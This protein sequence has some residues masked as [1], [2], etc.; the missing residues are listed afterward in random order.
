MA[1]KDNYDAVVIG[2]GM[3][4]MTC[5]ALLAK[6]KKSVLV[7][8]QGSKPGGCC[9]STTYEGFTYCNGPVTL[10][11]AP[12]IWKTLEEMGLRDELKFIRQDP[13][14]RV[15]GP[16]Y[17]VKISSPQS[18]E[19][20]LSELFPMKAADIRKFMA[21][22]K[23]SAANLETISQ[24]VSF[25][26][27]TI[28]QKIF[29]VSTFLLK[30][31]HMAKYMN[32]TER[33]MVSS[34]LK[35]PKVEGPMSIQKLHTF[36]MSA[37]PFFGPDS[38]ALVISQYLGTKEGTYL[39]EGGQQSLAN[40]FAKGIQK[41][42]GE[43]ALN[44]M[45][46]KILI[47]GNR[48]VG[49]RLSDGR[50][51]K[52]RHV[53]SNADI[54][55]TF[56]KLVGNEH[57][58]PKFIKKLDKPLASSA[59][60]VRLGVN[61]DTKTLKSMGFDGSL[62]IYNPSDDID[63]LFGHDPEKCL[64]PLYMNSMYDPTR[65]PANMTAVQMEVPFYFVAAKDWEVE[66]E[67]MADKLIAQA[68]NII[69]GLSEKIVS[70]QTLTPLDVEK[71]TMN[72]RGSIGWFPGPRFLPPNQKT[73]IKNLYLVGQWTYPG[74]GVPFVVQSGRNAAQLIIRGK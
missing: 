42:D 66:K 26:L 7:V 30:Y 16:G 62:I 64:L 39:P 33:K 57:L 21:A 52:S 31:R 3:G 14:Y 43:L 32:T 40:L 22:C 4:G 10:T 71:K 29:F 38:M 55:L 25:D 44:T 53:V 41:Y 63:A 70:R 47:E 5:G 34:F 72:Y 19:D 58:K 61:I 67:A 6:N 68:E 12:P 11:M 8:D 23:V 69:P 28:W 36:F 60:E 45:V 73:P 13:A 37:M 17:D 35:P 74:A 27:M 48:A 56:N 20:R 51:I 24:E 59:F 54:R 15:I 49:V 65:A 50:E 18:T 9:T 46:D 2:A 1:I